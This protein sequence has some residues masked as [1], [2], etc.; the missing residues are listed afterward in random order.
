MVGG[1][2]KPSCLLVQICLSYSPRRKMLYSHY[3]GSLKRSV[4]MVLNLNA[5]STFLLGELCLKHPIQPP[6]GASISSVCRLVRMCCTVVSSQP[7]HINVS[8]RPCYR[9]VESR[10]GILVCI[11]ITWFPTVGNDYRIPLVERF[12]ISI[13]RSR[14]SSAFHGNV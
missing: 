3:P 9:C 10:V 14:D 7:L 5:E 12:I 8:G 11:S 13:L 2:T 6:L 4:L 1:T